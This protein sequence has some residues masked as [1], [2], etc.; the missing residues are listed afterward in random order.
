MVCIS[1]GPMTLSIKR[2]SLRISLRTPLM[3]LYAKHLY[4]PS[5][6]HMTFSSLSF[7]PPCLSCVGFSI[8]SGIPPR[9][10]SH[11]YCAGGFA[12]YSAHSNGSMVVPRDVISSTSGMLPFN[13]F[14]LAFNFGASVIISKFSF[15]IFAHV[16]ILNGFKDCGLESSGIIFSKKLENYWKLETWSLLTL[17]VHSV[18]GWR[19][20]A[21]DVCRLAGIQASVTS[22]YGFK[23]HFGRN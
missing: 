17:D 16:I 23:S 13:V 19:T 8:I 1:G 15:H 21:N 18:T 12:S 9:T 6:D 4:S 10:C 5:S 3:K 2:S 14:L 22:H 20:V 7:L 11:L